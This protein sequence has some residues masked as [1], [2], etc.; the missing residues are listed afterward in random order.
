MDWR[1]AQHHHHMDTMSPETDTSLEI[2]HCRRKAHRILLNGIVA[3]TNFAKPA[4]TRI[5]DIGPG[6]VSFLSVDELDCSSSALKMDIL[7]FDIQTNFEFLINQ[8]TGW[9]KG[10]ILSTDPI[11]RAPAWRY[12]VEFVLS[13]SIEQNKLKSF[14]KRIQQVNSQFSIANSQ[15]AAY[16]S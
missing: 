5:Y 12:S 15:T 8:V 1:S 16:D 10:K 11:S 14:F 6:G 2:G 13:D 4:V 3:L 9:V 7:I